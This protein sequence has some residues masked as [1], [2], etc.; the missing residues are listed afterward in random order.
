[1]KLQA[2]FSCGYLA[3]FPLLRIAWILRVPQHRNAEKPG[4]RIFQQFQSFAGQHLGN[5]G[6]PREVS[7]WSR[8]AVNQP[9]LDRISD[10]IKNDGDFS[11]SVLSS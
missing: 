11:G 7:S 5:D 9:K 10:V 2:Q 3:F 4:N 1:M 6:E 8:Q